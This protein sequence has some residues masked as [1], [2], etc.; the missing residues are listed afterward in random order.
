MLQMVRHIFLIITSLV[1]CS[2]NN[3]FQFK[4]FIVPTGDAVNKR[5]GQSLEM[6][7]DLNC[8]AVESNDEYL[9]YVAT[10][11]QIDKTHENLSIFNDALRNDESASFGVILG[12]CIDVKDNLPKYLEALSYHSEKHSYDSKIFHI[13]GNH[14]LYFDGWEDFKNLIGPSVYWFEV[15]FPGGK[16][17]FISLDTATGTLGNKQTRWLKSFLTQNRQEYRHCFLLTHVNIFY[18]DNSQTTSGNLPI[19]ETYALID[20]LG[21][22]NVSL[23]LQG[24]DHYRED[25]T[26]NNVRYTVLGTIKDGT[27]APEYLKVHVN[28]EGVRL[29]W[30]LIN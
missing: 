7:Q 9:F 4:G 13:A 8:G 14:D 27:D 5:F 15:I 22:H 17:L 19:E 16:D 18:T 29:D 11:P 10:D 30:Q 21:R 24:H 25:L 1:L 3:H 26:Y 23:V 6:H 28:H 20:L 2:C 12:D